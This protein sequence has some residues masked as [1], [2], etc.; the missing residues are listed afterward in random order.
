VFHLVLARSGELSDG[1]KGL[2]L[3]LCRSEREDGSRNA[4]SVTRIEEKM[5]LHT[6]PTCQLAFDEAEAEL[7]GNLGDGLKAMFTMMNH[8]RLDVGLQGVAHAARAA[9]IARSYAVERKQ[10]RNFVTGAP[11]TIDQHADVAR[12]LDEQD[13]LA[14]GS[15]A[16]CHVALVEMES[17]DNPALVEFLTPLCKVLGTE[18]GMRA[19]NLG[20]QVLGGY[21]YLQEYR[22]EQTWRDAR[23]TAIYEGA[24]GIHALALATRLLR[25]NKGAIADAFVGF[26]EA[27]LAET[28][29][30]AVLRELLAKWQQARANVLASERPDELA[31]DFMQQSCQLAYLAVWAKV[32]AKAD[33]S[34]DADRLRRLAARVRADA[35]AGKPL[36][37]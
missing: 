26:V 7:V 31:H 21:G 29:E 22:V 28:G 14:V 24:N 33:A 19:A 12:M 11:A 35:A 4:I 25:L 17:G 18:A 8:A 9:D 34:V 3:F 1:V 36:Y 20:I 32:E 37:L 2:S 23:I 6:S 16:L 13:A 30:D 10:G 15:R 27:T 5:G